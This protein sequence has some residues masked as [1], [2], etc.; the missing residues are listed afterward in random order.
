MTLEGSETA[1][2]EDIPQFEQR[3]AA[4]GTLLT[5]EADE[6][7]RALDRIWQAIQDSKPWSEY[8]LGAK[9]PVV[10]ADEME[11]TP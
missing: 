5:P 9:D 1:T 2:C 10:R 4:G 3:T 7:V 6:I 11:M 8:A